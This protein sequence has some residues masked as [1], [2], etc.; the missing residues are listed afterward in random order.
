M[1]S[2]MRQRNS[3]SDGFPIVCHCHLRWDW[4]WQ[5]PQQ[6]L[7]RLSKRHPVLFVEMHPP[8]PRL[9][10]PEVNIRKTDFS[11]LTVLQVRFPTSRWSDGAYVDRER[12]RLVK[13]ALAG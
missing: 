11:G 7:S 1:R 5:R 6:F 3:G 8:S 12:R 13:E 9:S 4:V 2:S 10:K